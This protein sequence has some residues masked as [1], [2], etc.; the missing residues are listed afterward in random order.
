ME[1]PSS[2]WVRPD[3]VVLVDIKQSQLLFWPHLAN[4]FICLQYRLL[5]L[6]FSLSLPFSPSLPPSLSLS[7]CSR[8]PDFHP[9]PGVWEEQGEISEYFRHEMYVPW[10]FYSFTHHW[11][12]KSRRLN[13]LKWESVN[14]TS[15]AEKMLTILKLLPLESYFLFLELKSRE[16]QPWL[17]SMARAVGLGRTCVSWPS[18]I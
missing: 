14:T 18:L 6:V 9:A 1:S 2:S 11:A 12:K 4:V 16:I 13:I 3:Q 5:N 10:T 8:H 17:W 15:A 7:L